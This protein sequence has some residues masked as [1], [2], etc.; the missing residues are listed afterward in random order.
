MVNLVPVL[1][2]V[3]SA[4]LARHVIRDN[5]SVEGWDF[6][7][8]CV[9]RIDPKDYEQYLLQMFYSQFSGFVGGLRNNALKTLE[10]KQKGGL[11]S[12]PQT[13]I[14]I[15]AD[16][17]PLVGPARWKMDN[18]WN[19]RIPVG[20][21]G[22]KF[23]SDL[24]FEDLLITAALRE[25]MSEANKRAAEAQRKAAAY[26]KKNKFATALEGGE[27]VKQILKGNI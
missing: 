21:L 12:E 27:T 23:L 7:R 22:L 15:D 1:P 17:P 3:N 6:A 9:S 14:D 18:F 11:E 5:P 13:F 10:P 24:T 26:L 8:E 4:G 20:D 16:A 19:Q 25:K 2:S